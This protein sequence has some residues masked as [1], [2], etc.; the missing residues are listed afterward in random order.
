MSWPDPSAYQ[1]A[2]RFPDR[3]LREPELASC[4]VASQTPDGMPRPVAGA[5]THVYRLLHPDGRSFAVRLFL[6]P[7]PDLPG[8]L[9][10]LVARLA[11]LAELPA[12]FV[13]P[14]WQDAGIYAAGEW[15]PLIR[16]PWIEGIDLGEAVEQRLGSPAQLRAL[17]DAWKALAIHLESCGVVHGDLQRGNIL[18]EQATGQLRLIDYDGVWVPGVVPGD[19]AG[20][21]AFQHP[22]RAMAPLG[23]GGDRFSALVIYTALRV[24]AV[25]PEIWYRL[26]NG[27]NLLFRPEDLR[28]PETSRAFT[29]LKST[30]RSFPE[31]RTL[32]ETLAQTCRKPLGLVPPVSRF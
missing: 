28:L 9:S 10:A 21:P 2:L 29:L 22:G 5:Y 8:R 6:K 23:P 32:V 18:V 7:R 16:M 19:E 14:Q 15:R 24:L 27:D 1:N 20:H 31:E 3:S 12:W 30:L 25:T 26:D 11:A 17:A 13:K 4:M